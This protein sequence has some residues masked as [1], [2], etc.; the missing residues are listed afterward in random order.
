MDKKENKPLS[1][2]DLEKVSGGCEVVTMLIGDPQCNCSGERINMVVTGTD[3]TG[4]I[5]YYKCPLCGATENVY[6]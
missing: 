2:K 5:T 4:R 3:P 1:N 6:G